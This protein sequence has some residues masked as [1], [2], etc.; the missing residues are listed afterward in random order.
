M[1]T[2]IGKQDWLPDEYTYINE[3]DENLAF[4]FLES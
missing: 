1:T 2:T 4:I 3:L